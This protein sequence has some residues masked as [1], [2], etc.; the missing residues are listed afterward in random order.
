MPATSKAATQ[1]KWQT[2]IKNFHRSPLP[3]DA[4]VRH[5][6]IGKTTIYKWSKRLN[7]PL[8]KEPLSFLDISVPTTAL[9]PSTTF[10]VEVHSPRGHHLKMPL[11]WEQVVALVQTMA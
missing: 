1:Q 5:H 6:Q 8:K 4:Y 11:D 10:M 9:L 2:L 7:I 3:I